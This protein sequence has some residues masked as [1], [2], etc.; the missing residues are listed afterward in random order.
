MLEELVVDG[1]SLKVTYAHCKIPCSYCSHAN[2]TKKWLDSIVASGD[3][4]KIPSIVA[5]KD[6]ASNHLLVYDGNV[7]TAHAKERKYSLKTQVISD[8]NDFKKYLEKN[9]P[10]WFGIRNFDELLEFMRIY[11]QYPDPHGLSPMPEELRRKIDKKAGEHYQ[12]MTKN[13][14]NDYGWYDDN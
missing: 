5:V 3:F 7:R 8:E 9:N 6:P 10:L 1:N 12:E 4:S 2:N 13:R 14:N 11:S